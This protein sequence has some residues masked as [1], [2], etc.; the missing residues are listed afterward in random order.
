[1]IADGLAVYSID[2]RGRGKS[3]GERF[4]VERF[5]DYVSDVASC[6]T[7]ATSREPG[8]PVF[9]LGHSAGGVVACVYTI[10]NQTKLAGLICDWSSAEEVRWIAARVSCAASWSSPCCAGRT[11]GP[12]PFARG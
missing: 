3:D 7:L 9:L 8:L 5:T 1:L 4:Y 10:D 2:L 12:W 6:V 11:G